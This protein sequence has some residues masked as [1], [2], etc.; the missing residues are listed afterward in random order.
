[1]VILE[2]T[3]MTQGRWARQSTPIENQSEGCGIHH[4]AKNISMD[5]HGLYFH[6]F[7]I[8]RAR[9]MARFEELLNPGEEDILLDVGGYPATWTSRPQLTRR[10]DCMNVHSVDWNPS[11]APGHRI[12]TLV[13]DGCDLQY[14]DG[15]YDILFSNSVI[16]HVGDWQRQCDFAKEARRTGRKL[17][18]QTPAF[19]CPVEPHF[20]APF[21]HWLPVSVR[22]RLLR[23]FTPWGWMIKPTQQHIDMTIAETQLLTKKQVRQLFPDCTIITERFLLIFPKSYIAYR[24]GSEQQGVWNRRRGT[25]KLRADIGRIDP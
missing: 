4:T 9:R 3:E 16:E 11:L 12:K 6:I 5:I 20:L 15:S 10:I 8:W 24:V 25:A 21:V 19:G 23:W 22:R 18:I 14:G 17:W 7:R 2:R 13:G 1:M